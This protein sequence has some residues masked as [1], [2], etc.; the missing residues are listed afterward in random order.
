MPLINIDV[1]CDAGHTVYIDHVNIGPGHSTRNLGDGPHTLSWNL[2][3]P[4]GTAFTAVLTD[5][6]RVV[7]NVNWV[8]PGGMGSFSGGAADFN[9]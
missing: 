6:D 9:V 8:L 5:G 3:G 2:V 7:C 4:A 1:E